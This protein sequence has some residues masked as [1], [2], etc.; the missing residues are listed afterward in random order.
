MPE[1]FILRFQETCDSDYRDIARS[2]TQTGTRIQA[3]Q[4]DADPGPRFGVLPA[5]MGTTTK[6]AVKME[7]ADA[8]FSLSNGNV[9]PA[10]RAIPQMVTQTVTFVEAE[11][12][13]RDPGSREHHAIP[14]CSS[15]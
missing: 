7:Q 5:Q 6:S 3:E 14:R 13:D 12:A 15:S 9:L 11:A 1:A 2:G 10:R 4:P 8:D